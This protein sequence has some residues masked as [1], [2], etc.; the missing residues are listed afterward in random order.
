MEKSLIVVDCQ[1]DFI[2]GSLACENAKQAVKNIVKFINDN[3]N[4]NVF[5]TRDHH[6][7]ENKSFKKNGGIW[8]V[9]CVAGEKGSELDPAFY[10]DIIY[11]KNRPNESNT[12]YKGIDDD[13]EEYSGFGA[14]NSKGELL[15]EQ[16][17]LNILVSGL[18]SEYCCRQTALDFANADFSVSF[19]SDLVGYV[20]FSDHEKNLRDLEKQ[21]ITVI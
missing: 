21:K 12:F 9:H 18:A 20:N 16:A 8:P 3:P 5:Y 17:D 4:V 7:N 15:H 6:S 13:V 14:K 1:Y 10:E 19:L 2:E 11:E